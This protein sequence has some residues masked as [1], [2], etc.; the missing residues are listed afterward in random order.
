MSKLIGYDF[1]MGYK[2][3]NENLVVDVLSWE[4]KGELC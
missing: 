3:S 1:I 4:P 2:S